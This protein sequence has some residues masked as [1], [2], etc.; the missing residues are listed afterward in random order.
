MVTTKGV[1]ET[2]Q[3][4]SPN[5]QR[6]AADSNMEPVQPRIKNDGTLI[7]YPV[8]NDMGEK[9]I[10]TQNGDLPSAAEQLSR[11]LS[12]HG[13][14]EAVGKKKVMVGSGEPDI[15]DLECNP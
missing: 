6:K 4:A 11:L 10:G 13:K 5:T 12:L 15:E 9:A 14:E 2:D 1:E 8:Q 7:H 3:S